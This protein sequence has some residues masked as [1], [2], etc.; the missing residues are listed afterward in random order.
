MPTADLSVVMANRNHARFLPRALDAVLS[1]SLPP[2]EVIVLDDGSTDDSVRVLERYARR[3]PTVRFIQN[4]RHLGV[5]A[6]YNRGFALA[7]SR[8]LLHI[9]ADDYL[10]PGFLAKAMALFARHPQ[11]GVCT[12][13]G[14][15]TEGSN[16]ALVTNDPGWC[17]R[18]T[19]F[20][21]EEVCRRLWCSL[22]VSALII[23]RDT[24]LGA[25]GLLPQLAWYSDWFM[26]LV[27][28]FRHGVIHIPETLGIHV[29]YSESY[30]ANARAGLE[31]V[32]VLGALLDCLTAPQYSDVA[33][34]FRRNGC[35]CHFGPDLV[36][37]AALRPDRFEP[38]I[39]GLLTGFGSEVYKRL[40]ED[41]DD[42]VRR[43]AD[44]FCRDPWRDLIARRA[45]LEAENRRLVEEIQLTRLR[46]APPGTIGKIR[47]AAGLMRR[48]LRKAVGLHPA[49][50]F[51]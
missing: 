21:P 12:A 7:T 42:E 43:L 31:H 27:V 47:W 4:E 2:R 13:N 44:V 25:G 46:A 48:R 36:R 51:R 39:L 38:A 34:F 20:S 28:A 30:S 5:T 22:P 18:P 16:G 26:D 41:D 3:F 17:E 49:G 40:A 8:Y 1:Q 50:R 14:S 33:P 29:V 6:T 32:R 23:R 35:A 37:A 10:L 24:A 15:C 11:A 9:A 45:D 19:Y